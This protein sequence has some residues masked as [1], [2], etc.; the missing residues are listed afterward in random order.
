MK[1]VPIEGY[2]INTATPVRGVLPVAG[3][4]TSPKDIISLFW[5]VDGASGSTTCEA[6]RGQHEI[7]VLTR[8]GYI[9]TGVSLVNRA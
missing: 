8:S 4:V 2:D 9:V 3:F 6:W 7:D 1:N 5:E